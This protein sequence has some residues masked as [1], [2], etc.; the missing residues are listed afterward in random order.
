MITSGDRCG[1]CLRARPTFVVKMAP[2]EWIYLSPHFD[3]VALSCGGLVWQQTQAGE[4]ASIWTICGGD[5]PG[6]PFSPFAESLHAR[7]ET[8]EAAVEQRRQEDALS[9]ARLGASYRHFSIPDCIYRRSPTDGSFLYDSEESLTGPLHPDEAVLVESLRGELAQSL[10]DGA[11]VVSPLA[12]GGHVDHRL[13]RAAAEG[14]G[15]PLWFFADYPYVLR[16][17]PELASLPGAGLEPVRFPLSAAGLES[18]Q[19]AVAAHASQISSFWPGLPA[20]RDAIA[21]YAL[22]RGGVELWRSAGEAAK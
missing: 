4:R 6:R 5:P 12:L 1:K 8:G 21:E 22:R 15:R 11:K 7:W 16:C 17:E 3:D 19:G 18:W 20:M 14:M 9:C 2:M 13:V 10:P